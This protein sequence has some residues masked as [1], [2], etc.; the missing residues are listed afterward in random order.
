MMPIRLASIPIS[1]ARLRTRLMALCPSWAADSHFFSGFLA[2][3]GTRYLST[4]A[5]TPIDVNQSATSVPSRSIAKIEWPPPGA[6]TIAVPV[7]I[8]GSALWI[9]S[10]GT[11]TLVKRMRRRPAIRLSSLV[12]LSNS[13]ESCLTSRGA[14]P[15]QRFQT[16]GSAANDAL[17]NETKR[18]CE[19][20]CFHGAGL[21]HLFQESIERIYET[22][23]LVA[24]HTV[25][26]SFDVDELAVL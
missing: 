15:G 23:L 13:R 12:V 6:I 11:E 25:T 5:V 17:R 8:E 1:L 16:I 19:N 24:V 26:G 20:S 7:S 21:L 4:I 3:P 10:V 22:L 9:V 2:A 18:K 14:S